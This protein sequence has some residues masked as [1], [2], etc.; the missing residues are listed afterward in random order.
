MSLTQEI[1]QEIRSLDPGRK[2]LRQFSW[3]VGGIF[4]LIGAWLWYKGSANEIL[5]WALLGLGGALLVVGTAV[6]PLVR[7]FYYA[8][9]SLA[10]VLGYVVTRI[11]LTLFF[12]LVLTPVG[13]FFRLIGRDALKRRI[14]REASTY[15]EEK[16]YLIADRT[17]YEKFF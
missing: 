4:A 5:R 2:D 1:A 14:D 10:A 13:L 15:W 8:W 9:M 3:I 6:P 7:G 12:F 11:L 17:R 16:E